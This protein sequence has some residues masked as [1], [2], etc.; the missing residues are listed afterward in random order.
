MDKALCHE[1]VMRILSIDVRD[2]P[3]IADDLDPTSQSRQLQL[4]LG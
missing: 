4:A 2:A 3:A 1:K